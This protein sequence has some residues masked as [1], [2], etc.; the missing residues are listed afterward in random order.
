MIQKSHSSDGIKS[1]ALYS[2]DEKH[3]YTL[4]RIWNPSLPKV[5]FIGLNPSTATELKNDPTVT[6]M[7]NFAKK[8][9]FGSLTV[10]NLFA[11]RA[12]LPSDLKKSQNPIGKEND[13]WMKKEISSSEKIIAA[14]GN[15]GKF[16]NRS[17]E[18][19]K[20]LKSFSHFGFTKEG[21]PRHVLYLPSDARLISF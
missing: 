15:H 13:F 16:L 5:S 2:D 17:E 11:Y 8:W 6:R 12:T 7:I 18:V 20:F 3:R 9:N 4:T 21:E 1:S 14:W 10:L 19:L